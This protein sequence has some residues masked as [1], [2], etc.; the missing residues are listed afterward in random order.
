MYTGLDRQAGSPLL[1]QGNHQIFY[2]ISWFIQLIEKEVEF[3]IIVFSFTE[4]IIAN[5]EREKVCSSTSP[6]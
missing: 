5:N 3:K 2:M 4:E 1:Q 6:S